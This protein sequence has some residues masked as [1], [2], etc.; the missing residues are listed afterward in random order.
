MNYQFSPAN[1]QLKRKR[2]KIALF[3]VLALAP[4]IIYNLTLHAIATD[5]LVWD[6]DTFANGINSNTASGEEV[7]LYADEV[8]DDERQEFASGS[9]A[10]DGTRMSALSENYRLSLNQGYAFNDYPYKYRDAAYNHDFHVEGDYIFISNRYSGVYVFDTN[11]TWNDGTD[12]TLVAYYGTSSNPGT[13]SYNNLD[14]SLN[15][16]ILYVGGHG[17]EVIDTNGTFDDMSDDV[18]LGRYSTNGDVVV[19]GI[20]FLDMIID[21]NLIYASIWMRGLQVIDTKGTDTLADDTVEQLY[22]TAS[23]PA[24][25]SNIVNEVL[26]E[27]DILYVATHG[28]GVQ[29]IDT[30]GTATSTD[31]TLMVSYSIASTPALQGSYIKDILVYDDILFV[32]EQDGYVELIDMKGTATSSDDELIG[33]YNESSIADSANSGREIFNGVTAITLDG[34]ILYLAGYN[35][36]LAIDTKGTFRDISDD[37]VIRKYVQYI[38]PAITSSGSSDIKLEVINGQLLYLLNDSVGVFDTGSNAYQSTGIYISSPQL[39]SST[40]STTLS[41]E[42]ALDTGENVSLSYRVNIGADAVWFDDFATTSSYVGDTYGWGAEFQTVSVTDGILRLSNPDADW[43][44]LANF[45]TGYPDDY[46][47]VGSIVTARVRVNSTEENRSFEDW[48]FLDGWEKG[49]TYYSNTS[50]E[51]LEWQNISLVA[52]TAFS[53]VGFEPWFSDNEGWNP[54]DYW[55]ID[56]IKITTPDSFGQWDSWTTCDSYELCILDDMSSSTWMQYKLDLSTTNTASS[57]LVSSVTYR[58]DYASTGVYVSETET[59]DRGHKLGTFNVTDST[60]ASTSIAYEY[61][62]DGGT[63]WQSVTPGTD[64]SINNPDPVRSFTWR[65]TLTTTD[66]L[67][68]PSISEVTMEVTKVGGTTSTSLQA[69]VER[70][71]A[72]G[73]YDAVAAL[74]EKYPHFFDGTASDNEIRKE[75]INLLGEAVSKLEQLIEM[76]EGEN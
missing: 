38:S 41:V 75:M 72:E 19:P 46:F 2:E 29:A 50:I 43:G 45:D 62:T 35:G 4:L 16:D 27:G 74:K 26:K 63:T 37:E 17:Q 18:H 70:L 54:G 71:E 64:L 21:G 14:V 5:T 55:E 28:G 7:T 60:S 58:G 40:P 53:N 22:S 66:P 25:G 59:F 47:P 65:A 13:T 8:M 10:S 20:D 12:D 39:I 11:G 31:D 32:A 48:L 34:N 56:W 6:E 9:F 44:G 49:S 30:K 42:A 67:Y 52:D 24:I 1:I 51:N 69:Q 23:T 3:L 57:P 33:T 61:S 15:G 76:R 36:G 68:T 73:K